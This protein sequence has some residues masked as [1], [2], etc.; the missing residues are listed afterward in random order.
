MSEPCSRWKRNNCRAVYEHKT[1]GAPHVL[2]PVLS[3]MVLSSDPEKM[4]VFIIVMT[5]IIVTV[6]V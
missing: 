4:I 3:H 5:M 6:F 2:R 1:V